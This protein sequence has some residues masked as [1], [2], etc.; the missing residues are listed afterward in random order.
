MA[1]LTSATYI[2]RRI[3]SDLTGGRGP[4]V[5]DGVLPNSF[6]IIELITG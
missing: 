2:L 4:G 1:I 6:Y 3:T 5:L